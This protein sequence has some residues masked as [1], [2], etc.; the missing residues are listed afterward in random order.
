MCGKDAAAIAR[1]IAYT[2][3]LIGFE[4]V[5]LGS[6]YDGAETVPFAVDGLPLLTAALMREELTPA[7]ITQVMGGNVLAFLQKNLP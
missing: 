7:Q 6:D 5:A 2:G 3:K 1:A 4:H